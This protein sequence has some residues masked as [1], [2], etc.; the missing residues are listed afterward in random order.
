[1]NEKQFNDQLAKIAPD[2]RLL[3]NRER[4]L[5]GVYQVRARH[6]IMAG[7]NKSWLLFDI[8]DEHKQF[9]LPNPTDLSRCAAS[10]YSG[11]KMWER[12]TDW[13]ID[14]IEEQEAARSV[15]AKART[16]ET[17]LQAAKE[18]KFHTTV[19]TNHNLRGGR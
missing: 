4:R 9:R 15:A 12:G 3:F 13:Y 6:I 1:M 18:V 5:W 19:T 2:L 17:M 11:H 7:P 10:V 16:K 8:V 14:R